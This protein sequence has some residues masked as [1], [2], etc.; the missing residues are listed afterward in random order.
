MKK[1]FHN[2]FIMYN[3]KYLKSYYRKHSLFFQNVGWEDGEEKNEG[4]RAEC[5]G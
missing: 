3:I 1:I 4:R 2:Y 5:N